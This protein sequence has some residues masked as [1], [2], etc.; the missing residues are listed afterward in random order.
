MFFYLSTTIYYVFI[1]IYH[2]FYCLFACELVLFL[3]DHCLLLFSL[4]LYFLSLLF[5]RFSFNFCFFF[6][7]H[8]FS[9]LSVVL[10]SIFFNFGWKYISNQCPALIVL[11]FLLFS[12]ILLAVNNY[13]NVS[14]EKRV[15][16]RL[17]CCQQLT[18]YF[19]FPTF[20]CK[21]KLWGLSGMLS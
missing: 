4:N 15:S 14:T 19:S 17:F 18:F 5:S 6:S 10:F 1:S 16:C 9:K 8:A 3:V 12:T 13:L 21:Q 11:S 7:S 20:F 2:S